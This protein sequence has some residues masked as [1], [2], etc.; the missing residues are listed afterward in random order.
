MQRPK[1]HRCPGSH[2]G[3]PHG[4]DKKTERRLRALERAKTRAEARPKQEH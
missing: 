2:V 3:R 4:K 1:G